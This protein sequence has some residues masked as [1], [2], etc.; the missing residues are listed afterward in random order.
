MTQ[1]LFYPTILSQTATTITF[2][3]P[4]N[5][6]VMLPGYYLLFVVNGNTPSVG[7]WLHLEQS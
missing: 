5:P 7:K 4:D 3:A 6:T 2:R 1:R